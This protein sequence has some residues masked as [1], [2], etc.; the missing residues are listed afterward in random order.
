MEFEMTNT[1]TTF[2]QQSG[3]QRADNFHKRSGKSR[4]EARKLVTGLAV[5][6]VGVLYTTLTGEKASALDL[7]SSYSSLIA[8]AA[9][10]ISTLLGIFA[11]WCEAQ[12]S[13]KAAQNF[14]CLEGD[15]TGKEP[16]GDPWHRFK[17][18]CDTGQL[19][20]FSIGIIA[21]SWLP[22]AAVV[23]KL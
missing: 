15:V 4:S 23:R 21:A 1:S 22:F 6:S 20:V 18:F 11:W 9:M 3:R 2:K 10:G 8:L 16:Q 12:W 5:A 17:V 7:Y 14:R 13:Y 19:T